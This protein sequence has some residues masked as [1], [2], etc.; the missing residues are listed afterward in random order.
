VTASP[1]SAPPFAV[2][3]GPLLP[4]GANR[5]GRVAGAAWTYLLPD[6]SDRVTVVLGAP[7]PRSLP[8][9]AR[10]SRELVILVDSPR[11]QIAVRTR[12]RG[13]RAMN[14]RVLRAPGG[15]LPL[16]SESADL[17]AV[18]DARW[19]ERLEREP[20]LRRE[21]DRVLADGATVYIEWPMP[22][23][24]RALP[25]NV[26]AGDLLWLRTI[27]KEVADIA[28]HDDARA[29]DH[30]VRTHAVHRAANKEVRSW[31]NRVRRRLQR[32]ADRVQLGALTA[33]RPPAYLCAAAARAGVPIHDHRWTLS[34]PAGYPSK[35]VVLQLFAPGASTPAYLVKFAREPRFNDR[36]EN[37]WAALRRLHERSLAGSGVVPVPVF[38]GHE[39]GLA[40]AAESAVEG[41]PFRAR[42]TASPE[43]P[44]AR[45][46]LEWFLTLGVRTAD[47]EI[48]RPGAV[49]AALQS[50]LARFNA[51][52]RP[53]A[54]VSTFLADQI[55][56]LGAHSGRFP[57]VFQHGDPGI[58][59]LLV[60]G[61]AGP[62]VLD[63]EAADVH[64]MPLWDVLYF[65][66]S[67]GVWVA[68]AG[69]T[70]DQLRG[71]E[72]Q[73]LEPS[74]LG[75]VLEDAIARFCREAGLDRALVEPLFYTC[76]MHRALKDASTRSRR[77]VR[78]GR[79]F[80]LVLRCVDQRR[81]AG[82]R[83]LFGD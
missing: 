66:R 76:W 62:I 41:V 38:A 44:H 35:K 29:I 30:L 58:W 33:P 61:D 54:R 56:T 59:N 50:L 1:P 74:A 6:L 24:P 47:L 63:W 40:Y 82:L 20:A 18:T 64:G 15:R 46:A 2:T 80:Q 79:Y 9:L 7:P 49:G 5:K 23:L 26:A 78:D 27:R 75:D 8:T 52:Y 32:R 65:M 19:A 60:H 17:V 12:L 70:S 21:L 42:T 55:A 72:Q 43:C 36:I 45:A 81:S 25:V 69:G 34:A 68:R 3:L 4:P 37:S 13:L 10:S 77:N 48:A 57:V 71:F 53:A 39:G 73:F 22:E 83:R 51:V 11:R 31:P 14:A 67:F 28:P 16:A